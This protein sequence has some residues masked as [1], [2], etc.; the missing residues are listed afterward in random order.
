MRV[1]SRHYTDMRRDNPSLYTIFRNVAACGVPVD[2]FSPGHI[3]L[4]RY[5]VYH[6][7]W[8]EKHM[9]RKHWLSA[10]LYTA[11]ELMLIALA[12]L[13]GARIVW[14]VHNVR[15]HEGWY[16]RLERWCWRT[17]LKLVDASLHFSDAGRAIAFER[18]PELQRRPSFL[19]PHPHYRQIYPDHMTRREAR[20]R[21]GLQQDAPVAL[22]LG[23]IRPYKNV[24][25]LL[26]A[27][28]EVQQSN[29]RLVVAGRAASPTLADSI[30]READCDARVLLHDSFIPDEAI[31]D[32]MKA[33][34][35]VVL[36][37]SD[38]LNSG[39]ALLALSFHRPVLV[40]DRGAMRELQERSGSEWVRLF[41][42]TLAGDDLS[43]ALAWARAPGRPAECPCDWADPARVAADTVDAY[44]ALERT[45]S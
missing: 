40:A 45:E 13:R 27:F 32:Y 25:G 44:R 24:T 19:V 30:A 23:A 43:V 4:R 8:P 37:F 22:F 9:A 17:T 7:H 29:A 11:V 3:L 35:L 33:A 31:Q 38:V 14:T 21:L 36:P 1:V 12:R 18:F 15:S 41:D 26:R 42:G 39:S 10:A 5:T 34:D 20:E 2:Q 6:I 16:P 28:R